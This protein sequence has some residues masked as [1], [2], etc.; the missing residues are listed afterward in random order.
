MDLGRVTTSVAGMYAKALYESTVENTELILDNFDMFS[1]IC[2]KKIHGIL[3]FPHMY[4]DSI[5]TIFTMM[6]GVFDRKFIN[7]I[8]VLVQN[9]RFDILDPIKKMYS[10]LCDFDKNVQRCQVFSV[11]ELTDDQRL[12]LKQELEKKY[13]KTIEAEYC[14]DPSIIAGIVVKTDENQI[15][16]SVRNELDQLYEYLRGAYHE[17]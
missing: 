2:D 4:S 10:L 16:M 6:N 8:K 13:D 14:L 15:D 12:K 11:L 5:G 17:K 7:F 3:S 1:S 9:G